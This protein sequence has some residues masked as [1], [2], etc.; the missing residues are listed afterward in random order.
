[1][2]LLILYS[3]KAALGLHL[4]N[5]Q[6]ILNGKKLDENTMSEIVDNGF[7]LL[8]LARHANVIYG[9]VL[10]IDFIS[11]MI[12]DVVGIFTCLALNTAIGNSN[13]AHIGLCIAGFF[14][15]ILNMIKL[16]SYTRIG[17]ALSEVYSEIHERMDKLLLLDGI[18]IKQRRELKF[19]VKRFSV[20]APIRPLDMFD[21]NSANF[22]VISNIMMTYVIILMQFKGF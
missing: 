16:Y 12:M 20:R 7:T 8:E 4:R 19:L 18:S 13:P 9:K 21:M 17:Q 5:I 10:A 22:A 15:V 1:M 6:H 14:I 2:V 11:V 3:L